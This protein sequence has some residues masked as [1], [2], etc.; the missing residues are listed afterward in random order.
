MRL[1]VPLT[2]TVLVEGAVHGSGDLV[3]DPNDPIRPIL[4]DLGE[5]SWTMIDVDLDNGL[6]IIEVTANNKT[7]DE[8]SDPVGDGRYIKTRPT[9]A[10]EKIKCLQDCQAAVMGHTKEELYAM[11]GE[12]PLKRPFR[13]VRPI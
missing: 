2:G 8:T 4:L 3:G 10:A 7:A 12:S 9:T 11:T 6:M 13:P 1:S 5:V